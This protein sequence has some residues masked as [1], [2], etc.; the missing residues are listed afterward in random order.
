ML[1]WDEDE[2][3]PSMLTLSMLLHPLNDKIFAWSYH[4]SIDGSS[5][6]ISSHPFLI[7]PSSRSPRC[8]CVALLLGLSS[9]AWRVALEERF[10]AKHHPFTSPWTE[11]RPWA[12]GAAGHASFRG[13]LARHP[14][15]GG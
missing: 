4:Q 11:E 15:A 5:M 7:D 2:E 13:T 3:G 10:C 6:F 1:E 14:E 8:E 12:P 9:H